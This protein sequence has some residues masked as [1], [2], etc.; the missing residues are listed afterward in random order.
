MARATALTVSNAVGANGSGNVLLQAQ[1]G[2]LA[3]T[4]AV[5]SGSGHISVLSSGA[6][7]YGAAGDIATGSRVVGADTVRG[8]VDIDANASITMNAGAEFTTDGGNLRISATGAASDI[9]L[10]DVAAAT[11]SVGIVAGRSILDADALADIRN[12]Q[13]GFIFQAFN[14]FPTLTARQNVALALDLL[15]DDLDDLQATGQEVADHR[16]LRHAL[17]GNLLF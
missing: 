11:G 13:I 17:L 9:T 6:Q 15:G 16:T 10:G 2:A 8:T 5:S 4:A 7:T 3:V 12:H 1:A 14:L